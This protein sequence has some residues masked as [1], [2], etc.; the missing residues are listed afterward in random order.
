MKLIP[1]DIYAK[2]YDVQATIGLMQSAIAEND[3]N[4]AYRLSVD[5]FRLVASV[6]A[7][8]DQPERN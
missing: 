2:L 5:A 7:A 3:M 4:E 1:D 6:I 8:T